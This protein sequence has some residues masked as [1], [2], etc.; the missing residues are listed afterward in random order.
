MAHGPVISCARLLEQ[1]EPVV[2]QI[3]LFCPARG[4]HRRLVSFE[5]NRFPRPAS[6]QVRFVIKG[7]VKVAA[8]K[9]FEA[10]RPREVV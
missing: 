5:Q 2:P 6:T 10:R 4:T 3:L 9:A 8:F 7:I 1:L